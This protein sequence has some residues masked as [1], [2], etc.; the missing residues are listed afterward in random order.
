MPNYILSYRSTSDY[1]MSPET[2]ADWRTF[3]TGLGDS[4]LELGQP[5]ATATS[6][7]ECDTGSTRLGG[8]S[9][10][11]ADDL[12]A[13]AAIAKASPVVQR[14]GG[15]QIGELRPVQPE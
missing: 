5:V 14:D 2:K 11:Q 1:D 4:L 3:F 6:V 9:V 10:I 13:A 8:Y 15:V 7:G 12:D